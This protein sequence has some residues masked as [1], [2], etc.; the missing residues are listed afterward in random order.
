MRSRLK[1]LRHVRTVLRRAV[2]SRI[3]VTHMQKLVTRL[4]ARCMAALE[5]EHQRLRTLLRLKIGEAI[6]LFLKRR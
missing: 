1:Q 5:H 2:I 6:V 3:V 4:I